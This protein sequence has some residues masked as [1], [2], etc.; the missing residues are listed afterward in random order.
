MKKLFDESDLIILAQ[1]E[2]D[3]NTPINTL[4]DA[5][6]LSQASV[7]RRLKRLRSNGA[8]SAEVAILSPEVLGQAMTFIVM[9]E[10]E[11]ESVEQLAAF[12]KAIAAEPNV[13]Q[14]YYVTGDA[15]FVL[16]CLAPDMVEFERLT[17]RLFFK[18][19]NVRRFHTN[20]VM[21]RTKVGLTVPLEQ[22]K[23]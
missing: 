10:L 15:D 1:L 2:R 23:R 11:R 9:V 18:N 14:S 17:Q 19:P 8:I 3:A 12:K 20:V 21:N 6:G 4:V 22:A 7:Q 16:I 5:T 13:Q